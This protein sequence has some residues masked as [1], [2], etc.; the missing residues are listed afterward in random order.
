MWSI[1]REIRIQHHLLV[2][3]YIL[4]QFFMELLNYHR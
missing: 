4:V 1:L 3:Y 2:P